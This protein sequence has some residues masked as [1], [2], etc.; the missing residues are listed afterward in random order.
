MAKKILLI[1]FLWSTITIA[2]EKTWEQVILDRVE[3]IDSSDIYIRNCIPCHEYL[4]SSLERIFMTYL[5]VY[6]GEFT[7]KESIKA[8]LRNPDPDVSVMSDL[9]LDRFGIKYK[10]DLSEEEL[11]EAV[12]LYWDKYDVREKLK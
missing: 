2:E 10:T 5:K 3:D 6:S 12:N 7:I 11:D 8:Y 4:P 1:V 9:F